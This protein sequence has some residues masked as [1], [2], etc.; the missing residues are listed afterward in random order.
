VFELPYWGGV[1]PQVDPLD[2]FD[3]QHRSIT[4]HHAAPCTSSLYTP[5]QFLIPHFL[6]LFHKLLKSHWGISS[7]RAARSRRSASCSSS[8]C[9]S[10]S[11]RCRGASCSSSACHAFCSR[12]RCSAPCSKV[13]GVGV[14]VGVAVAVAVGAAA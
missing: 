10:S 9:R 5:F 1:E 6:F 2:R 8:A 3:V 12:F 7:C 11:P 13:V 4:Q 14:A